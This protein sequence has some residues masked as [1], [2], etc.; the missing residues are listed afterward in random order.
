MAT[1]D[2]R[3]LERD[4]KICD[5]APR[6]PWVVTTDDTGEGDVAIYVQG[7]GLIAELGDGLDMLHAAEMAAEAREGWPHAI[8]R[9]QEAEAGLETCRAALDAML[10]AFYSGDDECQCKALAQA[11]RVVGPGMDADLVAI[12]EYC[13]D[14][15]CECWRP[16]CER[17]REEGGEDV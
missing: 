5:K 14:G 7:H 13:A 15:D 3:D 6:G 8:R 10:G 16:E 17:R 11:F 12:E 1:D 9:A 2:K 4:M